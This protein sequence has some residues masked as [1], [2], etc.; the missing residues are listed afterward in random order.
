[1]QGMTKGESSSLVLEILTAPDLAQ[2]K[3]DHPQAANRGAFIQFN[4]KV[5]C[6][7]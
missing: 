2:L 6:F 3:A 7:V 1:M 5:D 4:G